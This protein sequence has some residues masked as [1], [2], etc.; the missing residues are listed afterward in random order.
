MRPRF[1]ISPMPAYAITIIKFFKEFLPW[2]F[3]LG[4]RGG[5]F[6]YFLLFLLIFEA[7]V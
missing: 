7:A 3:N 1:S 6:V 5:V 4:G 2:F